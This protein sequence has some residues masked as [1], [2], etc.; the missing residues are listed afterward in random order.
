MPLSPPSASYSILA[1]RAARWERSLEA[2]VPPDTTLVVEIIA[3]QVGYAFAILKGFEADGTFVVEHLV[4][5]YALVS[6][7]S[8]T[9]MGSIV[10]CTCASLNHQNGR[11]DSSGD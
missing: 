11:V 9:R 4:L 1:Q 10:I 6:V 8:G 5:S 2:E 7:R 3:G